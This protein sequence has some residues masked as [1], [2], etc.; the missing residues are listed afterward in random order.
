MNYDDYAL[1]GNGK[2]DWAEI[3]CLL[4]LATIR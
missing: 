4:I 3:A 2:N 1:L